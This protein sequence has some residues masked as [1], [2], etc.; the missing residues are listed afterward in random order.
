VPVLAQHE[1]FYRLLRRATETDP[2]RR[3]TS[4]TGMMGQLT[5]VLREVLAAS[6][7]TPRPAFSSMFTPELQAIGASAGTA[8]E[9][10][11][12]PPSAAEIAAGLPV[13]L[14]DS[15]DPAAGYLATLSAL[16]PEQ[17]ADTLQAAV[18]APPET[19][20]SV[21]DSVEAHLALARAHI[22]LGDVAGAS[23]VLDGLAGRGHADWRVIWYRGLAEILAGR[24]PRARAAFE[25]V[26]DVLPGE[27]APKLALGLAA[28]ADGHTAARYFGVVWTTDHA[29]VSAAFGQARVRLA[30]G[31]RAG[32]V[33]ALSKVP[34]TSSH[35]LAAQ[36]AAVRARIS[37]SSPASVTAG[38]LTEAESRVERLRLDPAVRHILIAEVLQAGLTLVQ[39]GMTAGNGR[40]LDCDLTDKGLRLGLERSY[41][42]LARLSA[43]R[44]ERFALVDLANDVRPRTL[45]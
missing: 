42:A 45:T 37:A 5:G 14:A 11:P 2:R 34:D 7:G 9:D 20:G 35:H 44:A 8:A 18:S 36:I 40:L 41:R 24:L 21:S 31:D 6:D 43:T 23:V 32:A 19:P 13:P 30:A 29:Y 38:D 22:A 39:G 16:G 10:K 28:E 27:L 25:A 33:E 4:V 15:T 26:Y 3:F 1:S 12:G 17:L